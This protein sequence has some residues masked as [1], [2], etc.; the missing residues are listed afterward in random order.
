MRIEVLRIVL[1]MAALAVV[2]IGATQVLMP[3]VTP[4][5]WALIIGSASW[6]LYQRVRR[7]FGK[8]DGLAAFAMTALL[9]LLVL[10]PTGLL[11]VA[12]VRE[13]GPVVERLR[14]WSSAEHP[15]VPEVLERVP[16]LRDQLEDALRRADDPETR[17]LWL[18]QA[19]G[20]LQELVHFGGNVLRHLAALF[21]T[22][23]T[24]FFVFRD[25]EALLGEVLAL[26]DRVA[27]GRGMAILESVRETVRAVFFGWLMTAM[28][29]GLLAMVGYWVVGLDAPV[30]MGFFTGLAAVIPFGASLIWG[31]AII[32]LALD[33]AWW[34]VIFLAAWSFLVVSTI[35]NFLR[36]LFISGPARVPF[37]LVFF[38]VLGGLASFGLLGLVLGPVFLAVLLALWREMRDGYRPASG[39][40]GGPDEPESDVSAESPVESGEVP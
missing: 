13:V 35:D 40:P 31:P 2:L 14:S 16:F 23:F 4:I 8:R 34:Q 6:P 25:G 21:L 17:R 22:V 9:V 27:S 19:T 3:F 37:I 29:Q 28:A 1:G 38:G 39:G 33:G 26:L 36:P 20:R 18:R 7:H 15:E 11:G 32:S 30:L 10:V 5:L 24:L 12:M